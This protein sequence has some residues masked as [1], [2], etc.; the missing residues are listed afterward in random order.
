MLACPFLRKLRGIEE[1]WRE[2]EHMKSRMSE[3]FPLYRQSSVTV[4]MVVTNLHGHCLTDSRMA[5][6]WAVI[7]TLALLFCWES[8][9]ATPGQNLAL[10]VL[11]GV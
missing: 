1:L 4:I 9:A 8:P 2:R 11:L 6:A 10:W 5:P 3:V 7:H